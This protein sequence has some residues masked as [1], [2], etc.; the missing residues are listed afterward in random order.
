[1]KYQW[2]NLHKVENRR[3]K[4][5]FD[6]HRWVL[7]P[8]LIKLESFVHIFPIVV[9]MSRVCVVSWSELD[10]DWTLAPAPVMTEAGDAGR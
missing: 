9:A 3:N 6:D 2:S 8:I 5:Q 1:M 4:N 10:T 7:L